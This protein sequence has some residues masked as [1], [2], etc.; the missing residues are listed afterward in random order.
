METVAG[1]AAGGRVEDLL[2]AAVE[3]VLGDAVGRVQS[4]LKRT[5]IR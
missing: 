2:A 4:D 3:V 1:E 5:I